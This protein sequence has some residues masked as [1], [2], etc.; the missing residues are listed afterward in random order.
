MTTDNPTFPQRELEALIDRYGARTV[1]EQFADIA[2][3]KAEHLESNWQ[4]KR[5]AR[6]WSKLGQRLTKL[7]DWSRDVITA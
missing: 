6:N 3:G 2:Y 5:S 4:D 7:V 1:L